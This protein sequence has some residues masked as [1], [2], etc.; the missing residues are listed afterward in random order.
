MPCSFGRKFFYFFIFLELEGEDL[1]RLDP[2]KKRP[3]VGPASGCGS[4]GFPPVLF[5]AGRGQDGGHKLS[6][7]MME[8]GMMYCGN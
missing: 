1:L 2:Q 7:G 4:V 5:R 8:E 3:V 6:N